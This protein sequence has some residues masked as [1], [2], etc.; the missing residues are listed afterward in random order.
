M[1]THIPACII[2]IEGTVGAGKSSFVDATLAYAERLFGPEAKL[3]VIKESVYFPF[4]DRCLRDPKRMAL[5]FQVCMARD[6]IETMRT[7]VRYYNR[8]FIVLIDRGLPGDIAFARHHQRSGNIDLSG[9]G[10][11]FGLLSHAVPYFVPDSMLATAP[12]PEGEPSVI[13]VA[14]NVELADETEFDPARLVVLYLR[15]EPAVAFGRMQKRA[16]KEELDGYTMEYF[17][18]LGEVYDDVIDHF[19]ASWSDDRVVTVDYDDDQP[20][21]DG[22]LAFESCAAVWKRAAAAVLAPGSQSNGVH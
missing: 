9:M 4:L 15:A 3:I 21:T 19:R 1:T 14:S 16:I 12:V 22:R 17:E 7:A 8:G 20:M 5:P 6:R 13:K 18:Q 11:Y 10:I 2:D